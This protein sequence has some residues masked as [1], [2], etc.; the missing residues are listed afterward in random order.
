MT[1]KREEKKSKRWHFFRISPDA[2][3]VAWSSISFFFFLL[4]LFLCFRD[5]IRTRYECLL[6]VSLLLASAQ[7]IWQAFLSSC[8]SL[9]RSFLIK[10]AMWTLNWRKLSR[11]RKLKK[12]FISADSWSALRWAFLFFSFWHNLSGR[13]FW[14]EIDASQNEKKKEKDRRPLASLKTIKKK[15]KQERTTKSLRVPPFAV[16]C[17]PAK[18]TNDQN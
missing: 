6:N 8:P 18:I 4:S 16:Y 3:T 7:D 12:S 10:A 11:D 5:W 9:I 15:R 1:V 2:R 14:R 17:S 13:S